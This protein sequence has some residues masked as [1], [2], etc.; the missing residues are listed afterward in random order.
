MLMVQNLA[1]V[2]KQAYKNVTLKKSVT[3]GV[4]LAIQLYESIFQLK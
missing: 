2:I 3:F 1:R 4:L